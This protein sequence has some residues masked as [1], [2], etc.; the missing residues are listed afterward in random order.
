MS[1]GTPNDDATPQATTDAAEGPDTRP[2]DAPGGTLAAFD[3]LLQAVEESLV[4]G[5]MEGASEILQGARSQAV[6]ASQEQRIQR[7]E[8]ALATRRTE[9]DEQVAATLH[10][11]EQALDTGRLMD[12]DQLLFQVGE[13]HADHPF[14][15]SLHDRLTQMRRREVVADVHDMLDEA[16]ALSNA[17]NDARAQEMLIKVQTL[18]PNDSPEL[19]ERIAA[20]EELLRVQSDRHRAERVEVARRRIRK[21]LEAGDYKAAKQVIP[22]VEGSI[23]RADVMQ[24]LRE[25]LVESHEWMIDEKV[26][27]AGIS[28]QDGRYGDAVDALRVAVDLSPGNSWLESQLDEAKAQL[29]ESE[30]TRESD[31]RWQASK[32]RFAVFLEDGRFLDA[33]ALIAE[34]EA[35]WGRGPTLEGMK[36]EVA[37]RRRELMEH[38]LSEARAA[39]DRGDLD[40]AHELLADARLID[41]EDPGVEKLQDLLTRLPADQ[42]VDVAPPPEA[43]EAVA[44]VHRLRDAGQVLEAWKATQALIDTF[45]DVEPMSSLRRLIAE[46]ML[47]GDSP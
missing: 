34:A 25:Y 42:G 29:V 43:A 28:L 7:L 24:A 13:S 36:E 5:D 21:C 27:L 33:Q 16:Q 4:R 45:G 10:E 40:G 23:V 44:E 32:G 37:D 8:A 30:E 20:V 31:P 39:H 2:R 14:V 41:P 6:D 26:R 22:E 17:R 9:Q 15:K 11:I 18:A 38:S 46:D 3:V 35:Q 1:D 12:A 47:Q 19:D